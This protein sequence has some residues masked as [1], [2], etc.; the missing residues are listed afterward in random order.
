M[1]SW[2]LARPKPEQG[3]PAAVL[4][5]LDGS[6]AALEADGLRLFV[7]DIKALALFDQVAPGH[8]LDMVPVFLFDV[9]L[10]VKLVDIAF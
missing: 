10:A 6:G 4:G 2:L 9:A 8:Q 1:R 5:D 7:G 3:H